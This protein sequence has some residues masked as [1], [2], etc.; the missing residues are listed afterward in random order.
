[1]NYVIYLKNGSFIFGGNERKYI[2]MAEYN[3]EVSA[4]ITFLE[5]FDT[6]IIEAE[7]EE[8]AKEKAVDNFI[9]YI[10]S[11]YPIGPM[12]APIGT[13]HIDGEIYKT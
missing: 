13:I 3:F 1:M 10:Y 7:T 11:N 4:F 8:E 5:E 9:N 2:N 6:G 12:D